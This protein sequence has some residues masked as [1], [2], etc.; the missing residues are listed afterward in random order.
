MEEG[1]DELRFQLDEDG[2]PEAA[3][4]ICRLEEV[5]GKAR[6]ESVVSAPDSEQAVE[7]VE[8]QLGLWGCSRRV[9]IVGEVAEA[10]PLKMAGWCSAVHLHGDGEGIHYRNDDV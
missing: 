2:G 5:S 4:F 1:L 8:R 6:V 3:R 10:P 9:V 7:L